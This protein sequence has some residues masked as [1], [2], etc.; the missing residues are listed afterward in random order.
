MSDLSVFTNQ[1]TVCVCVCVQMHKTKLATRSGK[2]K[3]HD[4][5]IIWLMH[6]Q[7]NTALSTDWFSCTVDAINTYEATNPT[8]PNARL[9]MTCSFAYLMIH[10]VEDVSWR[11]SDMVRLCGTTLNSG[12]G[13]T[14]RRIRKFIASY[15]SVEWS[16]PF[17]PKTG[18]TRH[19]KLGSG[20][21]IV[22]R[23]SFAADAGSKMYAIKDFGT[24]CTKSIS[25]EFLTEV[26]SLVDVQ[27]HPNSLKFAGCWVDSK[28][29][30]IC[31]ELCSHGTLAK[32]I[33][34]SGPFDVCSACTFTYQLLSVVAHAH[35]LGIA[36]RDIKPYNI[37][38]RTDKDLVL[39]DWDSASVKPPGGFRANPICTRHYRAPEFLEQP[40]PF[41]NDAFKL[42]SWSI[43]CVL[44]FMAHGKEYF[45]GESDEMVLS[46]IRRKLGTE[47]CAAK[48]YWAPCV[49][50]TYGDEGVRLLNRLLDP[51]PDSRIS[52][53]DALLH[54]YFG[55]GGC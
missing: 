14:E 30:Y 50:D 31:Y 46:D 7:K 24:D 13:C 6:I 22:F 41:V 32:V 20:N 15:L 39:G 3:T 37:L 54:P 21:S 2:L 55:N 38:L 9:V 44:L 4:E 16:P 35:S 47:K 11:L 26:K 43:G 1:K 27:S 53:A 51:C 8:R 36:H 28:S 45:V 48:G 25:P 17:D 19:E 33:H 49:M 52:P 5:M 29:S 12:H 10:W 40:G 34:E 18:V 23:G 42:D